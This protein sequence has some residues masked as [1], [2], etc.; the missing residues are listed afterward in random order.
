MSTAIKVEGLRKRYNGVE[1]IRG[2][3]FEIAAGEI[4]GLLGPNGA[5]KTTTVEILEGYRTR[6][7][8]SVDVLGQDPATAGSA[9]RE[10]IGVVLQSSSLYETL[11]VREH[12]YHFA[13]YYRAPRKVDEVVEVVGLA[14][15]R[16]AKVRTLSGGQ[17]RRLD[18]GLALIGD[19]E[20]IFLDE[21]TTGFDPEARRRAWDT[22]GSLRQL[23]KT[24]LLTTHYLEEAERLSDR[25]A[26]LRD[27][28]IVALGPPAQLTSTLPATEIRF[29][30]DGQEVVIQTEE[31]TRTLHELT[32]EALQA[33]QELEGLEVRRANLEDVYLALT[34]R[35]G[36]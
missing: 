36:E 9:W 34:E 11:S 27:G 32:R 17:R 31:P 25:V 4:F 29:R 21:P 26:V 12:L 23:G 24:I 30:R 22:I 10:D 15:K 14:E 28:E 33:G 19:P 1:A 16:D 2:V 5:G 3:S 35:S 13:G 20:V 18:L 8:G 6:D 7:A